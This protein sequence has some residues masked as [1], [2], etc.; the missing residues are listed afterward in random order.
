MPFK[1]VA[2]IGW[3]KHHFSKKEFNEWMSETHGKSLPEK[4]KK[5][6]VIKKKKSKKCK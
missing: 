4:V 2:Q 6:K 3:A 5:K 1:S